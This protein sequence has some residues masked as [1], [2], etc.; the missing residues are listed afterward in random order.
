MD[1]PENEAKDLNPNRPL[2]DLRKLPLRNQQ[3]YFEAL[4]KLSEA[5]SERAR[6]AITRAT[7]VSR[8]P[9]CAASLAFIHPTFFP[10]DPFHLFYENDM[11]YMWDL[12][13]T[14]SGAQ[15]PVHLSAKKAE[16]FGLY[17]VDAM[18]TLPPV[19][20]G[21]IRNPHLKRQSQYKVFE[22]M[23]LLHWYILPM[24][25]EI[26][27]DPS[28]LENF[29]KFVEIIEFAM[30]PIP[31]TEQDLINLL[32][33]IVD[34]LEDFEK[35]YV[36]DKPENI[37]R[38]RLC[39]FQLI[40]IPLHIKWNGSIRVGSQSTVERGIGEMA[41]KIR[42]LKSP[43]ANLAMEILEREL[44]ILLSLHFPTLDSPLQ[45]PISEAKQPLRTIQEHGL[46]KQALHRPGS[47]HAKAREAFASRYQPI[48]DIEDHTYEIRLWGKLRLP[49]GHTVR[50][51]LGES[52]SG[53]IISRQY[54]WF[55]VCTSNLQAVD[56]VAGE[57]YH[58]SNSR[59][60][61]FG[62]AQAFYTIKFTDKSSP[63]ASDKSADCILAMYRPLE[64]IKEDFN[65][66]SGTW[67]LE[68]KESFITCTSIH[69]LVGIWQVPTS[70]TK[71]YILRKHPAFRML[72]DVLHQEQSTGEPGDQGGGNEEGDI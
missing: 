27:F 72:T 43:Y 22:W 66:I 7:G 34:F 37:Q 25:M 2:Y 23:A 31:R 45:V 18:K 26:G 40:H 49:N 42:S 29:A 65:C 63:L 24:G 41:R 11:P 32:E 52:K 55:E 15:D 30:T 47:H 9:L 67:A 61:I 19:F 17:V 56:P 62:E 64:S 39:I 10:L 69:A 48:A 20:S 51:R 46:S 6:S 54:R 28:V 60:L 53:A 36:Q 12:W 3:N 50:S 5:L 71:V 1:P 58:G 57:P 38:M 33:L 4:G 8:L 21:P 13:T 14:I 59:K 35:V 44:L 70:T 16:K 68:G